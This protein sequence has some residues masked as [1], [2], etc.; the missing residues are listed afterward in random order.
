MFTFSTKGLSQLGGYID[1]EKMIAYP[2][3][4]LDNQSRRLAYE[5]TVAAAAVT[6][7]RSLGSSRLVPAFLP[8]S[9]GLPLS[10]P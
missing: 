2:L 9:T 6:R 5:A 7:I 8:A 4:P 3:I 1:E 10:L